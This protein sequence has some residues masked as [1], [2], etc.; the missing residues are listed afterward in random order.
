MDEINLAK[1]EDEE[2]LVHHLL[3]HREDADPSTQLLSNSKFYDT[4]HPATSQP[5][6]Q[7]PAHSQDVRYKRVPLSRAMD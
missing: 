3:E 5:D 1:A 2:A 7:D 6:H 4:L